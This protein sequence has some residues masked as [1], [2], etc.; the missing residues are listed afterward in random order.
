LVVSGEN[1]GGANIG[2]NR[3]R[4][5]DEQAMA[6][7]RSGALEIDPDHLQVRRSGQII[8]LTPRE[9]ALLQALVAQ[10]NRVLPHRALL[11]QAWGD[12]YGDEVDYLHTYIR[13]LR[14]KIEL[15]PAKPQVL[16]TEAGIGYRLEAIPSEMASPAA[17]L[18][19]SPP[20]APPQRVNAWPQEV[21][22]RY[23]GR[24]EV[25]T[26]LRALL[27]EE[28]RLISIYGRSGMG[29]TA[30]AC[31]VLADLEEAP[32]NPFV[33]M[34]ALS[35]ATTG[36]SLARIEAD[37]GKLLAETDRF[38]L[39]AALADTDGPAQRTAALLNALRGRRYLV[40]LDN[41]EALQNPATGELTDPQLAA[42]LEVL[43]TQG[44]PLS[45]LVTS[46]DPLFLP[47][48][49]KPWER[50]IALDHGL[51]TDEAVRLLRFYD[52]DDEAGLQ[53]ASDATCAALAAKTG[54]FPRALL[55]VAGLLLEDSLLRP[56]D[57]LADEAL[58]A[59]EVGALIAQNAIRRLN[60]PMQQ[61]MM[62]SA[63]LGRPAEKE[64]FEAILAP[65]M[66][67][68]IIHGQ[69]N[70]LVRAYFLIF[71]GTARTFTLTP[72]DR[73]YCLG[74]IPLGG[75]ED[76]EQAFTR[77]RLH[78]EMAAYY[79]HKSESAIEAAGLPAFEH[80]L[81][82]GQ[83][84]KAASL[85]LTMDGEFLSRGGWDFQLCAMYEALQ[86]HLPSG[87]MARQALIRLGK[88]YRRLG[89]TREAVDRLEEALGQS[90]AADDATNQKAAL[91]NLAWAHYELG[92]FQTAQSY[93]RQSLALLGQVP[94]PL[95]EGKT[96]SGLGWV[97]YLLG[98][99]EEA[100]AHFREALAIYEQINYADG[101]A[102]NQGDLGQALIV[103]GHSQEGVA[104]LREAVA[105]A[106]A[107]GL[108]RE[109]S[110][111]G[112][113]LA[114]ALLEQGD[115]LGAAAAAQAAREAN[116]AANNYFTAAIH[117]AALLRLG[118]RAEAEHALRQ[119]VV[120][121]DALISHTWGLFWVRYGRAFAL[122]GLAL[123]GVE[124]VEGAI[125][126]YGMARAICAE[127]GVVAT[128]QRLLTAL[129]QADALGALQDAQR[130]L[131]GSFF[132]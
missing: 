59:G 66:E 32:D 114:A 47:R 94:D 38:A 36:I 34:V 39:Q 127:V 91:N 43:L 48:P 16:L 23:V 125:Q 83:Y 7:L 108:R 22:N 103:Q 10:P 40:L 87:Q 124:S 41:L 115:L 67:R 75:A 131:E 33:G 29:K 20:K 92:K 8:H 121:A 54:G 19:A 61:V 65:F 15:D 95:G 55:A 18:A 49:L 101:Q 6:V 37:L 52:P 35:A 113:Y 42:F 76:A 129:A 30:L 90:E 25:A 117:G 85:L 84:E 14:R 132:A 3:N 89:R 17:V 107:L 50:V 111:K 116:I 86:G 1:L 122:A 51:P 58:F 5:K 96:R 11:Q 2:R 100:T 80:L 28:A 97:A 57:I 123:L 4:N 21:R 31:K 110:Y 79:M 126:D 120:H 9:W 105:M 102:M 24:Q 128:H 74:L 60:G 53:S 78:Q 27:L 26:A 73:A 88:M 98:H 77:H 82:A 64:A 56:E 69:L 104:L 63:L 106:N 99:N 109:Q 13:R 81:G 70:R 12:T 46:S 130:A 44:G 93:L 119:S 45:L 68:R 62:A 118:Q 71:D 112:G 72:A